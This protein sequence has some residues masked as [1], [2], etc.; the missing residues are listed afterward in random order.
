[1]STYLVA[2][3]VSDFVTVE[4]DN[5]DNEVKFRIIVRKDAV[6]Q[7]EHA[8]KTVPLFLKYYKKYFN[9]SFPLSKIDLAAIPNFNYIELENFGLATFK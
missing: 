8:K 3:M 4:S 7:T 6:N 9:K 2:Y 5:H 1:M